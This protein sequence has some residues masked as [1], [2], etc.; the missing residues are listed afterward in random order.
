MLGI[1]KLI[2]KVLTYNEKSL[3][4]HEKL[5]FKIIDNKKE[6]FFNGKESIDVIYFKLEKANI[7]AE[8]LCSY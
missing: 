7:N 1:K 6:Q 8:E 2:G 5:G 3:R 4:F